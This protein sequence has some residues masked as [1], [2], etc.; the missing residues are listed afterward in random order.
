MNDRV[1]T[2]MELPATVVSYGV[3]YVVQG[4]LAT[5]LRAQLDQCMSGCINRRE[6]ITLALSQCSAKFLALAGKPVKP[7]RRK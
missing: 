1:P 5:H 2:R 4:E 6:A 7:R 3:T